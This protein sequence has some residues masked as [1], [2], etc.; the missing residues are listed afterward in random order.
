MPGLPTRGD[1][2]LKRKCFHAAF[3]CLFAYLRASDPS[4]S[5]VMSLA[6]VV[7]IFCVGEFCRLYFPSFNAIQRS[8][9]GA[10]MREHE[11]TQVSGIVFYLSGALL[12]SVLFSPTITILSLLILGFADPAASAFGIKLGKAKFSGNKTLAGFF[13]FALV[14]FTVLV[15][16]HLLFVGEHACSWHVVQG[17]LVVS[18]IGGTAELF[19]GRDNWLGVDDNFVI[20]VVI[21]SALLAVST[22]LPLHLEHFAFVALPDTDA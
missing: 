12:S 10:V 21:S 7:A 18:L 8:V 20:P 19:A 22:W 13:G 17:Y 5:F 2:H 4:P 14:S 11:Q 16:A 9:F 15:T 1:L 6:A 3:G